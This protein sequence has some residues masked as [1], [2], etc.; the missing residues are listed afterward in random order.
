MPLALFSYC[1]WQLH[2]TNNPGGTQYKRPYGNVLQTWIAKSASWYINDPLF[3]AKFG[4]WMDRFSKFSPIWA[5]I[6]SNLTKFEKKKSGNFGQ[7][8]A[9]NRTDWYINGMMPPSGMCLPKPKLRTPL[10]Q[11][12]VCFK[13]NLQLKFFH[14]WLMFWCIKSIYM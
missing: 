1:H 3:Y 5:K 13:F 7:N 10:Q 4:I 14:I 8:L 9:Q 11:P 2:P 6:G 12:M